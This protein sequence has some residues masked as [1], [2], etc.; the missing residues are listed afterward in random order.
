MKVMCI[1]DDWREYQ[2]LAG[3]PV[4]GDTDTVINEYM[5]NGFLIYVLL[6]RPNPLGYYG[7]SFTP[8]SD[9]DETE[10]ERNYKKE[11]V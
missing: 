5:W 9:I 4:V 6:G 1:N 11:L 7:P 2:K 3:D 8:L 10:F